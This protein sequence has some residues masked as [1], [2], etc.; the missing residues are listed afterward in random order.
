MQKQVVEH[1]NE[2]NKSCLVINELNV[3]WN[4]LYQD[5]WFRFDFD[6]KFMWTSQHEYILCW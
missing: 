6:F 2:S 4:I 3:T 5:T 1:I